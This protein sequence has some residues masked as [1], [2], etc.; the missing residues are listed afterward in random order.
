[1]GVAIKASDAHQ[2]ITSACVA[3]PNH[4][5]HALF[6]PD[7]LLYGLDLPASRCNSFFLG[8][9]SMRLAL[10]FP[11]SPIL[12]D[13]V[14]RPLLT[15]GV[16]GSIT[17]KDNVGIALVSKSPATAGVGVDLEYISRPGKRSIAKR[18]LTD[19]ENQSLGGIPGISKEE[20]VMLRFRYE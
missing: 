18:V 16:H 8:R 14:G 20:E 3:D 1:M 11:D 6:H 9:L 13:S 5:S 10:D 17:H 12:K 7:E 2:I 4:W 15:P 19:N